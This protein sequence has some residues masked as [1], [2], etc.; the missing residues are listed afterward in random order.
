M[1]SLSSFTQTVSIS[2]NAYCIRK[3]AQYLYNHPSCPSSGGTLSRLQ[4]GYSDHST[5]SPFIILTCFTNCPVFKNKGKVIQKISFTFDCY[6]STFFNE[7]SFYKSND[8]KGVT[9]TGKQ[10]GE[11]FIGDE[12]GTI[13]NTSSLISS[14]NRVVTFNFSKNENSDIFI[15]MVKYFCSSEEGVQNFVIFDS[16]SEPKDSNYKITGINNITITITYSSGT[17]R[18]GTNGEWR[19]CIVYYGTNG[20]WRQ[21]VPYFGEEGLWRPVG[22]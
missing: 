1:S 6:N 22:G 2:S 13:L 16:G 15:N 7:L 10:L 14:N 11:S 19:Q 18:Y 21:V 4:T 12:L 20:E 3:D 8:T 5:K 9:Y 17:L